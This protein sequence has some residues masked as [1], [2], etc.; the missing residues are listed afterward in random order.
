MILEL[1]NQRYGSDGIKTSAIHIQYALR[2]GTLIGLG[3]G[4]YLASI[5]PRLPWILATI[6]MI[7]NTASVSFLSVDAPV[8][9]KTKSGS[10]NVREYLTPSSA[11]MVSIVAL[12]PIIFLQLADGFRDGT[13]GLTFGPYFSLVL[14]GPQN[15]WILPLFMIPI[16]IFGTSLTKHIPES[17]APNGTIAT[18][19]AIGF[20][21]LL[22]SYVPTPIGGIFGL[23]LA[24][25]GFSLNQVWLDIWTLNAIHKDSPHRATALSGM[26]TLKSI[27]TSLG[28]ACVGSLGLL[29]APYTSAYL[30]AGSVT[31]LGAGLSWLTLRTKG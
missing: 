28:Y 19:L 2:F 27:V 5:D 6:L 11:L 22:M 30:L 23:T 8:P 10:F 9:S 24:A 31:I 15:L 1:A 14:G 7:I 26:S 3:A 21:L 12:L 16:R 17:V 18:F 4:G 13:D 25:F 29:S 20:S